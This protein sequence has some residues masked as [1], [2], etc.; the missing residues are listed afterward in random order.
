LEKVPEGLSIEDLTTRTSAELK[1]A[2]YN[3]DSSKQY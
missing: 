1:A 3:L 2:G